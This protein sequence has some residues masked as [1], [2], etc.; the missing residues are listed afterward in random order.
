MADVVAVQGRPSL[1]V[2][3]S[4][5]RY[6]LR[7]VFCVGRNYGDHAREMGADPDLE[8]PF[9]FTKPADAVFADTEGAPTADGTVGGPHQVPYPSLTSDLQHEIE[10]VVAIERGAS[11]I[12]P[13][14]A[15]D[16]VWGYGVGVDLTRRDLQAEAKAL[17]RPWDMSKG[18]DA[19][20]PCSAL[21]PAATIGHPG[22]GRI[23][24]TVDGEIRQDGDLADQ[25][26]PV[27]NVISEL[28]RSI[29]LR[30]GDLIF[31]GTPAGVG[32]VERGSHVVG[33]V[34]GVG[35]VEFTV[36]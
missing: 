31:T 17:R 24:L 20:G 14:T 1:P 4:S 33:G 27:A 28:S 21:T 19:S 6:P 32:S 29:A 36:I 23:W 25:L 11:D 3:G 2:T 34:D 26:W 30:P 35:H 7:R 9:F 22:H 5:S 15:L 12:R 10:L 18:F 8:P 16:H 13:V